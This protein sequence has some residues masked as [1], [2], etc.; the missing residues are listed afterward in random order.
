MSLHDEV[1]EWFA[2]A[3]AVAGQVT[4]DSRVAEGAALFGERIRTAGVRDVEAR[5][6]AVTETAPTVGDTSLASRF[7]GFADRLPW[8]MSPRW[9]D[10]GRERALCVFGEMFELDDVIA[11][12]V[13]LGAGCAYPE[14]SHPPQELYLTISGVADW[15]FG[16]ADEYVTMAPGA[17]L[18]NHPH[19]RHAIQ[20]GDQPVV[21][22]Y[23]LWGDGVPGLG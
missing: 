23:V 20:A 4:N 7:A 12:L 15:R 10:D 18:Y 8:S 5:M 6:Q 11:G 9:H 21:A 22:M 17:T 19:D 1:R 2:D 13:Y 3:A 14:H 16:G